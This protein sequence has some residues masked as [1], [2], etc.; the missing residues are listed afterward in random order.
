MLP[1]FYESNIV[2]NVWMAI[3][4]YPKKSGLSSQMCSWVKLTLIT[5]SRVI[6]RHWKSRKKIHFME[7]R[8]GLTEIA[9]F[10]S[11]K[12]LFTRITII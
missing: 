2:H 6:L 8:D 1:M 10:F 3:I 9:L 5:G 4:R 12:N 11:L 7:W